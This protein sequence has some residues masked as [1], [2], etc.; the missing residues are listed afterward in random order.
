MNNEDKQMTVISAEIE[1]Q[2]QEMAENNAEARFN[3]DNPWLEQTYKEMANVNWI[4]IQVLESMLPA[5]STLIAEHRMMKEAL[6]EIQKAQGE[7]S[8]D[9]LEHAGNTIKSMI[10][11]ATET[12]KQ[13][14]L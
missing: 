7:Y 2:R 10:N 6:E 1:R 14:T 8:M 5:E 3:D 4:T 11:T 13:V 9:R 12:L